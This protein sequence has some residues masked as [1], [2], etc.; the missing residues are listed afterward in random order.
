MRSLGV[1]VRASLCSLLPS[2]SFALSTQP[3]RA[4][5]PTKVIVAYEDPSLREAATFVRF[6][7]VGNGFE[8][9]VVAGEVRGCAERAANESARGGAVVVLTS[10]DGER[11][12]AHVCTAGT[13]PPQVAHVDGV[14]TDPQGL[15]ILVTEAVNGLL[16]QPL[17]R[18][19][20]TPAAERK[21]PDE[22]AAV[23]RE[24]AE[25]AWIE[26]QA[27]LLRDGWSKVGWSAVAPRIGVPLV[28]SWS[29]DVELMASFAPVRYSEPEMRLSGSLAWAQ[30]GLSEARAAGPVLLRYGVA[31]GA[32]V[33]RVVAEA[34]PPWT[35][36]TDSAFGAVFG[37]RGAVRFPASASWFVSGGLGVST[38]V[39]R[40]RYQMSSSATRDMG[41][42]L[43]EGS[44]G[45]GVRLES[46]AATFGGTP[47]R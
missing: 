30:A 19:A 2:A 39:P 27:R 36:G 6:D 47:V 23:R 34:E 7:L 14:V 10:A 8:A 3:A 22:H 31:G 13:E 16:A 28:A 21:E 5:A 42:F 38:L 25:P 15:S 24:D 44:L 37:A 33:T 46:P 11:V 20:R 40:F 41:A 45:F 26:I 43:V 12:E 32:Y 18:Q 17:T 9:T 4:D 29:L 35:D 1:V